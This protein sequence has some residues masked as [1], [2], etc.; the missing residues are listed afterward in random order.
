[1]EYSMHSFIFSW[2]TEYVKLDCISYSFTAAIWNMDVSWFC[3][4]KLYFIE[5]W[6]TVTDIAYNNI[7]ISLIDL[8][9]SMSYKYI[10]YRSI[11][12]III[13]QIKDL[14]IYLIICLIKYKSTFISKL[15]LSLLKIELV[16]Y[17]PC[18]THNES[19]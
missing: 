17:Q 9:I 15:L 16:K 10:S 1:M 6:T 2:L 3:G 13:R 19:P 12:Y 5:T 14:I 8:K 4:P 18:N 11:N 7:S